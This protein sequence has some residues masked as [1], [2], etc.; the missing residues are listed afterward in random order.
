MVTIWPLTVHNVPAA[1]NGNYGFLLDNYDLYGGLSAIRD[2]GSPRSP[3]DGRRPFLLGWSPSN[4][5]GVKDALVLE[6]DLL[7]HESQG[8]IDE[9][10][11]IPQQRIVENPELWRQGFTMERLRLALRDFSDR[12]WAGHPDEPEFL[13]RRGGQ[14]A[15]SECR[16]GW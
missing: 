13:G 6:L 8:S 12:L 7:P 1:S 10:M 11:L 16:F 2:A 4:T 9:M 3:L 14:V 15:A 5:R